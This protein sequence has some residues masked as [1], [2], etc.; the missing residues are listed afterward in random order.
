M[1]NSL[2]LAKRMEDSILPLVSH[3]IKSLSNAIMGITQ[4]L[5]AKLN[6][7]GV[8]DE[9]YIRECVQLI[10]SASLNMNTLIDD[11]VAIGKEQSN[12]TLIK[13]LAVYNLREQLECARDTFSYEALA[14]QIELTISVEEDIPVVYWDIESLR[15][16]AINNLLSNAIRHTPV[17]GKISMSI[18]KLNEG[19]LAIKISDSGLGIPA[20]ERE[21][22]F[23]R[24]IKSEKYRKLTGN[25]HGLGLYNAQLCAQAH[26][27]SI[28]V[29]DNADFSGATFQIELPLYSQCIQ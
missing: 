28:S 2:N 7:S 23:R 11:L 14:K 27:G 5:S 24:H 16:H 17:G 20:S 21:S 19:K 26:R 12:S 8:Q 3:D 6:H 25:K 13:P 1:K 15:I 9:Q 18:F 22:L 10:R 29:V 4:A